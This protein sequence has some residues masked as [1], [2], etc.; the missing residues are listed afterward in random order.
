MNSRPR[1]RVR[2]ATSCRFRAV[3]QSCSTLIKAAAVRSLPGGWANA[4]TVGRAVAA[5]QMATAMESLYIRITL[6]PSDAHGRSYATDLRCTLPAPGAWLGRSGPGGACAISGFIRV[7][8][9]PHARS[10]VRT[11]KLKPSASDL[12]LDTGQVCPTVAV[13]GVPQLAGL[14]RRL[15]GQ[16]CQSSLDPA[17]RT[18]RRRP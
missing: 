4:R 13:A 7:A 8:S 1:M 3:S 18:L 2:V 12:A 14:L 5:M 17:H 6:A 9:Q 11:Q 10:Q 15:S 16:G